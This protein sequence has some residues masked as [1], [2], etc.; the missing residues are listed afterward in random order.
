M[1][2]E[3]NTAPGGT[4]GIILAAGGSRRMGQPK[5]LIKINGTPLIV[6]TIQAA[7]AIPELN[8]I[9]VVLGAAEDVIRPHIEALPVT[10]ITC[11]TWDQGRA[12][13][14]RRA[15]EVMERDAA[16]CDAALFMLCDQPRLDTAALQQLIRARTETGRRV[17]AARYNTH[18]GAPCLIDRTHFNALKRITGDQGARA[19]LNQ[20]APT[21]ITLVDLPQLALDLDTPADLQRWR[22]QE[23]TLDAQA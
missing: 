17:V 5:Q 19:L 3:I 21:E 1:M 10:I 9:V 18:P 15:I 20:L 23:K 22:Q 4:V 16:G 8:H 7:M 14:M 13:S 2:S 12:E 6:R 11:P